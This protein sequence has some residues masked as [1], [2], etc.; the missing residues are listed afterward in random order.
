MGRAKRQA[1]TVAARRER[2][3]T[4]LPSR[5]S[6]LVAWAESAERTKLG[7]PP[8]N[9]PLTGLPRPFY[10]YSPKRVDSWF[11]W[12]PHKR[13]PVPWINWSEVKF[14]NWTGFD[15][16]ALETLDEHDYKLCGICGLALGEY[17]VFGRY[18]E[19][20]NTTGPG[21]HATCALLSYHY[22]PYL[23]EKEADDAFEIA[24]TDTHGLDFGS[25]SSSHAGRIEA[26]SDIK[27]KGAVSLTLAKLHELAR[28]ERANGGSSE[29]KVDDS[30][31]RPAAVRGCPVAHK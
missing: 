25:A 20:G 1:T 3:P 5:A 16:N 28:A 17:K 29:D 21:M 19:A 26:I 14:G 23:L 9:L 12:F 24:Y 22:C 15:A 13:L 6:T 31:S 4:G 10:E 8:D 18:P 27:T 2:V 11:S 7:L 30:S